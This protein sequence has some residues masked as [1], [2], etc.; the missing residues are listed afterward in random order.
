MGSCSGKHGRA[1]GQGGSA[2]AADTWWSVV[3]YVHTGAWAVGLLW[4]RQCDMS[5]VF[6]K[7]CLGAWL[8]SSSPGP[9]IKGG[10]TC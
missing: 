9:L 10:T 8:L 1:A 2:A 4:F 7:A 5:P 3:V 6:I